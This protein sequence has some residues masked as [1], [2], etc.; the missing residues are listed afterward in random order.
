MTPVPAVTLWPVDEGSEPVFRRID[1]LPA[2]VHPYPLDA[3]NLRDAAVLA[4]RLDEEDDRTP[5]PILRIDTTRHAVLDPGTYSPRP[6]EIAFPASARLLAGLIADAVRVG[7]A[8]GALIRTVDDPACRRQL[9][10][11]VTD[12]LRRDGF[13][14]GFSIDGWQLYDE[15]LLR[16]S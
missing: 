14:V 11:D 8:A 13:V 3:D 7:V 15:A 1:H 12:H 16:V 9:L 4:G 5:M 10:D 6:I 2:A